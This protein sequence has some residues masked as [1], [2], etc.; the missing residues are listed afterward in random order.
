MDLKKELVLIPKTENYIKYMLNIIFKLPRTE[1][2]SIGNEYKDTMYKM[3]ED[4]LMLSKIDSEG[5]LKILNRIDAR[6]NLQRIFLRIMNDNHWIDEKK[7]KYVMEL[8]NELGKITG[9]LIKYH[10][11]NIKKWI[12]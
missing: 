4:I 8:I 7:F 9:G 10:A 3:L 5:K 6:L 12:W 11:Q 1:K 2:F